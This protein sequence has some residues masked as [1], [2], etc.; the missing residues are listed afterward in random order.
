MPKPNS[1]R[2]FQPDP[3]QLALRPDISGNAI[4]G[5]GEDT[6]RRPRMVY[7][8]PDPDTIPHGQMQRWFYKANP[9]HP[10]S[11]ARARNARADGVR[12][13]AGCHRRTVAAH[14][15]GLERGA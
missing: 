8:A 2:P 9:D 11:T 1:Y 7:W 4:N 12:G 14:A 15:R 10:R 13:G 6:P 3:S 5:L